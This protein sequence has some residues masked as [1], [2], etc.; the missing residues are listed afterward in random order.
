MA[1]IPPPSKKLAVV[2]KFRSWGHWQVSEHDDEI[3]SYS[4][5]SAMNLKRISLVRIPEGA[6]DSHARW[7]VLAGILQRS[8]GPFKIRNGYG[9]AI[10]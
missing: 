1:S 9:I 4:R 10:L 2:R 3:S 8:H 6:L 7:R 5:D